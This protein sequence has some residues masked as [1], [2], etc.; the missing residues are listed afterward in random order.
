MS[1]YFQT[2]RKKKN[3]ESLN[4]LY[5]GIFILIGMEAI[6][7]S[8]PLNVMTH[9]VHLTGFGVSFR[10]KQAWSYIYHNETLF[11]TSEM[12]CES[13]IIWETPNPT[14]VHHTHSKSRARFS[15]PLRA[16]ND[17][18][19]LHLEPI[20]SL[21]TKENILLCSLHAAKPENCWRPKKIKHLFT[22][23]L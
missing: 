16:Q 9:L 6:I 20:T 18:R 10:T 14:P 15:F 4:T 23:Y 2:S 22:A 1:E 21:K 19:Y 3:A 7:I 12:M 8:I 11:D 5:H 17:V 13:I